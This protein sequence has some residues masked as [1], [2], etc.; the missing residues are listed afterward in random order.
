MYRH[1]GKT[2]LLCIT[3][4]ILILFIAILGYYLY[5]KKNKKFLIISTT[6]SL[7][8]TGLLD[9]IGEKFSAKY[10]IEV[11]FISAGT[12]TSIL[13]AKNGDAEMIL[14]HAPELEKE[15][16][17]EGYGFNRRIFAYNFFAIVGKND[18]TANVKN[19][20]A[21]DALK[22]IAE[23]KA[24]WVSRGDLSGTNIR[25]KKLWSIA[26]YEIEK[27][28][29]E[30]WFY[31]TGSGMGATL[32]FANE[33]DAYTLTDEGT[34]L[35]YIDKGLISLRSFISYDKELMNVY[36]AIVVSKEKKKFELSVRFL[37]YLVSDEGQ[38]IIEEFGVFYPAVK[39]LDEKNS[40]E[41]EWIKEA[42]FINGEECPE[43]YRA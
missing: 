22:K 11:F 17:E 5:E 32:C 7:Y 3:V 40:K 37:N 6:T 36:S 9:R 20:S 24:K 1:N 8:D 30:N 15:F 12:G 41:Y 23:K 4:I 25:E 16:M 29:K 38:K 28:R 2:R 13:H 14:A 39:I 21:I 33:I 26:G 43:E 31:E 18:D 35:K 34:Y 27:L 19:S 42:A 10:G